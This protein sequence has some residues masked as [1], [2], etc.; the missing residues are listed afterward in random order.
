MT[1]DSVPSG[2][3]GDP[4]LSFLLKKEYIEEEKLKKNNKILW[5]GECHTPLES[6]LLY[7]HVSSSV[8]EIFEDRW[9][10]QGQTDRQRDRH[11]NKQLSF[12][13]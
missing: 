1:S 5:K 7:V 13:I 12:Y 3:A 10:H 8:S 6:M 11:T 4:L 9:T 2:D